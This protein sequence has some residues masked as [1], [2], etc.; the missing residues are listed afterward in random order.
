MTAN[1]K[2]QGQRG[3]S[4]IELMIAM[5]VLGV[6]LLGSAAMTGVSIKTNTRSKNDS[7]STAIA[8]AVLGEI[9]SVPLG[10][11]T[12]NVTMTDCAGTAS[13]VNTTGTLAGAG[14]TL[15]A[16]GR[17]DYIQALGAVPAGYGMVY[18]ACN[19]V[20]GQRALYDVRWNITSVANGKEELVVVAARYVG[21]AVTGN[22]L[23]NAPAVNLRTVVGNQGE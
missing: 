3:T 17:V 10:G 18:A 11:G 21:T 2:F 20:S 15:N 7:T 8:Q 23:G 14:A 1:K 4:L 6:G 22:A 13:V 9:S 16:N 5:L 12:T 19:L